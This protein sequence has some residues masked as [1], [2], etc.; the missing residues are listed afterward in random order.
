MAAIN[1]DPWTVPE[2]E[3]ARCRRPAVS[4]SPSSGHVG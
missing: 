1:L 3:D 4:M 2:Q